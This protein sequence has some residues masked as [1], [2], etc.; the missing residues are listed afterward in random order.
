VTVLFADLVG[1]TARASSSIPRT[2]ALLG[3]YHASRAVSSNES[4]RNTHMECGLSTGQGLF[5]PLFLGFECRR[6]ERIGC[7]RRL[8]RDSYARVGAA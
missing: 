2:S 5:A 6:G 8:C 4:F 1:F 3:P 7:R